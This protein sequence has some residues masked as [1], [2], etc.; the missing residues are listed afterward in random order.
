MTN[1]PPTTPA[2]KLERVATGFGDARVN[3]SS[4]IEG[5]GSLENAE[6]G[7]VG[8]AFSGGSMTHI[9]PYYIPAVLALVVVWIFACLLLVVVESEALRG[10]L[11]V[12]FGASCLSA[13]FMGGIQWAEESREDY[14]ARSER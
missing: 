10:L 3:G 13:G 12:L 2:R 1:A 4:Q 8:G 11:A 14:H 9:G 6:A 5:G 7:A